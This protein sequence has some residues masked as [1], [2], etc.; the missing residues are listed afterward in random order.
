MIILKLA[1]A[2]GQALK[3]EGSSVEPTDRD[4]FT[5]LR[6]CKVPDEEGC[7]SSQDEE[8]EDHQ[9]GEQQR[10]RLPGRH[11]VFLCQ[12][13]DSLMPLVPVLVIKN[14]IQLRKEK[15]KTTPPFKTT[16]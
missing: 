13:R 11:L 8:G 3:Q 2:R 5:S 7:Y 12:E 14:K 15:G 4:R 6:T 9:H 16:E 10:V 1:V